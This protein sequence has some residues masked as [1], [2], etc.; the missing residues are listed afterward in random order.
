MPKIEI[1][2]LRYARACSATECWHLGRYRDGVFPVTSDTSQ[3]LSWGRHHPQTYRLD[4]N[5]DGTAIC[6]R[7]SGLSQGRDQHDRRHNHLE[8]LYVDLGDVSGS[9]VTPVNGLTG[10]LLT[11]TGIARSPRVGLNY[12]RATGNR[13]R[14]TALSPNRDRQAVG[15]S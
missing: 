5:P 3:K 10:G 4:G 1:G 11:T 13:K 8:Y 14:R 6:H 15:C 12:R 2:N 9:F 7:R